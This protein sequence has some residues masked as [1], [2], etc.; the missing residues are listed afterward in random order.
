LFRRDQIWF[1]EKDP[2]GESHLYSLAEYK[3]RKNAKYEKDYIA[4]KY[5]AIP[6]I[7]DVESVMRVINATTKQ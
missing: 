5:G 2:N 3:I 1:A 6:F 4:G 7:G